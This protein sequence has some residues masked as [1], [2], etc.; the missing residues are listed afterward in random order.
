[1]VGGKISLNCS[2]VPPTTSNESLHTPNTP[3]IL[4][5]IVNISFNTPSVQKCESI[6]EAVPSQPSPSEFSS[7]SP[8]SSICSP[9]SSICSPMSP[10]YP[11]VQHFTSQ[12]IKEGLK[13]KVSQNIKV[14]PGVDSKLSIKQE[15]Q[16][17]TPDD[18]ERRR[19][20]R[21]RNKVA[22]TKCR[23]KKKE[24][25]V[26]LFK[27]SEIVES[28]NQSLKQELSRLECEERQL[29]ELLHHH[30]MSSSCCIA[31]KR[32]KIDKEDQH[33]KAM[34]DSDFKVPQLPSLHTQ[35]QETNT[36]KK[37]H[38]YMFYSDF[39]SQT[40]AKSEEPIHSSNTSVPPYS[41]YFDTMC[42]AI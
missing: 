28:Q 25:T 11:S 6:S 7:Y 27:E 5:T 33:D 9:V 31:S 17:L 15:K 29:S 38:Q 26:E 16:E 35:P 14:E 12:L 34:E 39:M 3:E 18:V 20:R 42:Y 10:D 19:R 8:A 40:L 32:R 24:A 36:E 37:D 2:L 23:N 13:V 41:G 1:M 21:E 4:N 22:A 30:S